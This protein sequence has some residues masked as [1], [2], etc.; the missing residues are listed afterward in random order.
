MQHIDRRNFMWIIGLLFKRSMKRNHRAPSPYVILSIIS[1][2]LLLFLPVF[3]ISPTEGSDTLSSDNTKSS[4]SNIPDPQ[5]PDQVDLAKAESLDDD[6]RLEDQPPVQEDSYPDSSVTDDSHVADPFADVQ[7]V[8][9]MNEANRQQSIAGANQVQTGSLYPMAYEGQFFNTHAETYDYYARSYDPTT[10]TW[11]QQDP[12]RGNLTNPTSQHRY[13]YELNSPVNYWDEYG[14]ATCTG[15]ITPMTEEGYIDWFHENCSQYSFLD[16]DENA[17]VSLLPIGP[18]D[19]R[20]ETNSMDGLVNS[21]TNHRVYYPGNVRNQIK[22]IETMGY[23]NYETITAIIIDLQSGK[24]DESGRYVWDNRG[25]EVDLLHFFRIARLAYQPAY[26]FED[27]GDL[28]MDGSPKGIIADRIAYEGGLR[29]I[30][31]NEFPYS[32]TVQFANLYG[33]CAEY[34]EGYV[35]RNQ[36]TYFSAEDLHSNSLGANFG[37]HI[38]NNST[39]DLSFLLDEFWPNEYK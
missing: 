26:G 1:V 11:L 20:F 15:V 9:A 13:M 14:F 8:M 32:N 25:N 29:L 24:Y 36:A 34:I 38:R 17:N 30:P 2:S 23:T 37:G 7:Q 27:E 21:E 6:L 31:F 18:S 4:I 16:V 22:E 10:G 5:Q 39:H 33:L 12:Y 3:F 19:P 35:L 28:Y